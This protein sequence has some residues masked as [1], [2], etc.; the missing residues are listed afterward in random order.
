MSSKS[1]DALTRIIRAFDEKAPGE[2]SVTY[3]G[4]A[5]RERGGMDVALV[6]PAML[7]MEE[8]L[9]RTSELTGGPKVKLFCAGFEV[10]DDEFKILFDLKEAS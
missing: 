7:A 4:P 9:Q 5:I 8:L 3:K 6:A 2:F 1:D 10:D